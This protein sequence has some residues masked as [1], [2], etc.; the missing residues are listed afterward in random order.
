[1]GGG[2]LVGV[3]CIDGS[4]GGHSSSSDRVLTPLSTAYVAG[5]F[6]IFS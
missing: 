4:E 6:D 3:V 2:D 5:V 1:M